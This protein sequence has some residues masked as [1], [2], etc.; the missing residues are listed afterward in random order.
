M[1]DAT[2]CKELVERGEYSETKGL[3]V[4]VALGRLRVIGYW[5][6]SRACLYW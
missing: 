2:K 1:V 6:N 5:G 3:P 4:W